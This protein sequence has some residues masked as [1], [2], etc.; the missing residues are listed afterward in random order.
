LFRNYNVF[1]RLINLLTIIIIIF[2]VEN[3]NENFL[4]LLYIYLTF[5]LE[6][7][8][9][10]KIAEKYEI[11]KSYLNVYLDKTYSQN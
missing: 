6:K 7:I 4:I 2:F 9:K 8:I 5:D 11:L 3:K 10:I 1:L